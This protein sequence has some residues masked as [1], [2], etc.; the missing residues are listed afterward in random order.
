MTGWGVC[1]P[2]FCPQ[3][4]SRLSRVERTDVNAAVLS[5]AAQD[6]IKEVAAVRQKLGPVVSRFPPLPVERGHGGRWSARCGHASQRCLPIRREDNHPV[7]APG[8]AIARGR[9][10][11]SLRGTAGNVDLLQLPL[12]EK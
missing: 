5:L 10:A 12:R 8:A 7:A 9:I 1:R 4:V 6:K 3:Y 2:R 11:Q